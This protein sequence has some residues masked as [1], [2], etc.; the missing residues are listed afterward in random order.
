M[1][2]MMR[3][4]VDILQFLTFVLACP[5]M[6][7][8]QRRRVPPRNPA[9]ARVSRSVGP[10]RY[11]TRTALELDLS[12]RRTAISRG[13]AARTPASPSAL[14]CAAISCS[15]SVLLASRTIV[16]FRLATRLGRLMLGDELPQPLVFF[17]S[18][19]KCLF[20]QCLV[21]GVA[22]KDLHCDCAIYVHYAT[23]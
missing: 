18:I 19:L 6:P 23:R 14:A 5:T 21:I 10:G 17:R 16:P 13:V 8:R 15:Q 1:Q 9:T 12:P 20:E 7:R 2:T 11:W 4:M 22:P 3:I